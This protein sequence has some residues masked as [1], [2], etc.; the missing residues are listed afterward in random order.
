[1]ELTETLLLSIV[2]VTAGRT[3]ALEFAV[4]MAGP[5]QVE[6]QTVVEQVI[7]Q[8]QGLLPGALELE[9]RLVGARPELSAS[10]LLEA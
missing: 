2:P 8:V 6:A 1:M 4:A 10:Q 5:S 3:G 9:A 7:A